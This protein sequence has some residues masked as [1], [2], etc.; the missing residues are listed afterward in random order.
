MV[1]KFDGKNSGDDD[2]KH[3]DGGAKK[4]D[5]E[6][7]PQPLKWFR[8]VHGR[9]DCNNILKLESSLF[10]IFLLTGFQGAP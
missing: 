2:L 7:D 6:V 9:R 4:G 8:F 3:Q 5:S 10:S 1:I